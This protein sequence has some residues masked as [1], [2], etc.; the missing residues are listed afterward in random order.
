MRCSMRCRS[1]VG[2]WWDGA[3][4]LTC[5]CMHTAMARIRKRAGKFVRMTPI[6]L[7]RLDAFNGYV[8]V[9]EFALNVLSVYTR[10]YMS[11]FVDVSMHVLLYVNV[12]IFR[13]NFFLS[14]LYVHCMHTGM[15]TLFV[16]HLQAI[17]SKF[18]LRV[19]IYIC[20]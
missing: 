3:D 15:K 9:F 5:L 11:I 1:M 19:L 14:M 10:E 18:L 8:L 20:G 12:C 13:Y 2:A 17:Q 6:H 7:A 4:N 16:C